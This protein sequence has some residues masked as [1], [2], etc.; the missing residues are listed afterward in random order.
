[1]SNEP[2]YEQPSSLG[3]FYQAH[4]HAMR[5]TEG[6]P[7]GESFAIHK[8]TPT[9]SEDPMNLRVLRT[10]AKRLS[11][12]KKI[13]VVIEHPTC[14]EVRRLAENENARE[15]YS[16]LKSQPVLKPELALDLNEEL[17][18]ER[19]ILKILSEFKECDFDYVKKYDPKFNYDM[20]AE[21]VFAYSYIQRRVTC[22]AAFRNATKGPTGTIKHCLEKLVNSGVLQEVPDNFAKNTF[23]NGGKLFKILHTKEQLTDLIYKSEV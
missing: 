20:K 16:F 3:A 21:N 6:Q 4:T 9:G 19:D 1:M 5:W 14:F 12:G 15:F 13:F 8:D 17:K 7:I 22:M 11:V 18:A 10:I 2:I 23:N